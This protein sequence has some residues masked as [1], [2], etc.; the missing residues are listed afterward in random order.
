MQKY[1]EYGGVTKAL[2]EEVYDMVV[3]RCFGWQLPGTMV[4]PFADCLNHYNSDTQFEMFNPFFH[5]QT[6]P[7]RP[8]GMSKPVLHVEY[9][10]TRNKMKIDFTQ[11]DPETATENDKFRV[12]KAER[13]KLYRDNRKQQ[14]KI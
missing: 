13:I 11:V 4:I 7:E 1:P 3:S 2:F 5:F 8:E 10:Q 12:N 6:I 14:R 9:Y